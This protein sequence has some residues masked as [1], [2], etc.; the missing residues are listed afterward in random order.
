MHH[1][2][3]VLF[4]IKRSAPLKSGLVPIFG[5]IAVNGRRTQFST[6]LALPPEA[7]DVAQN[8]AVGRA[9]EMAH[10]NQSLDAIRL[11]LERCYAEL[12]QRRM[13]V[14]PELVKDHY[15]RGGSG[16]MGL[17]QLVANHNREFSQQVGVDRS[18]STLQKY[19]SVQRHL[20]QFIPTY[21]EDTDLPLEAID[22]R[23]VIA[24][25]GYLLR[26]LA[27]HKNTVW[28][29]LTA[30]KHLLQWGRKQGYA[31]PDPFDGYRL[32]SE[33]VRRAFLTEQELVQLL[34]LSNLSPA[35]ALVRDLYLFS[36]FTGLSFV[37]L[38][39]ITRRQLS[40]VDGHWW[41][42]TT[43]HKTGTQVQVR[44]FDISYAI[45][46]KYAS[47][48]PDQPI[49]PV[50]SNSWCNR[51]LARLAR[52]CGLTKRI[53]FHSARHTFATTLTLSHGMPIEAISKLLG[54]QSIRTTQIYATITRSHLDREM[55]RLSQQLEPLAARWRQ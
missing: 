51:C 6:R 20:A 24:F 9:P 55:N 53:T 27:L 19:N 2:F 36:C 31:I 3:K 39:G 44:L 47:E 17:L 15:L 40:Y 30:L 13:H 37:D 41:I 32:R 23:F 7:W 52:M 26:E 11:E 48:D 4:Y 33:H 38:K 22:Q 10:I 54:H 16:R 35:L 50:P 12:L 28:I 21:T 25:H 42:E 1:T 43:R 29:Y 18:P 34:S 14:T 46:E 8:R 49:F 5:R 45:V